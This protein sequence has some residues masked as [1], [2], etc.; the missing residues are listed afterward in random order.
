MT[1]TGSVPSEEAAFELVE[2][3][4]DYR[5]APGG[6]VNNLT[7]DPATPDASGVR[8]VELNSVNF[9][10]DTDTITPD[11]ALQLDR[12]VA[13]MTEL[14]NA[15]VHVVGNT[16]QHGEETRNFVV[17]QRRAEAVVAYFVTQGVDSARLTTQPAGE[18]NPLSTETSDAADA[19][20]RRT[21]FVIFGL[22]E[23]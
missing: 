10:G 8:V 14:P 11:Q 22:L 3:A 16:D 17:S 21:E 15:Q 23:P 12:M 9:A 6:I 4:A 5:L 19:I 13:F 1:L 7:I 18:S 20:N 2:F